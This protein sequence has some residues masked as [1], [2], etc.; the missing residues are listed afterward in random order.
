MEKILINTYRAFIVIST[1]FLL[2]GALSWIDVV[3]D[4]NTPNPQ[5]SDLNMFVMFCGEEK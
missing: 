1:A 2:W 4:N 3:S 5:H